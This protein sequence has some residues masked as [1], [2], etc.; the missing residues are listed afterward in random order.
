MR[1]SHTRDL[2]G[3]AAGTIA[4]RIRRGTSDGQG[5]FLAVS[6]GTTPWAML[7]RL[8]LCTDIRWDLVHVY[9]VDERVAPAGHPDRN[10]T[11]LE[12][13]LL[14]H[15]PAVCHP[16]PVGEPDLQAAAERY[17]GDLPDVFDLVHLGLGGD[18]H[19]ASL[20]PADPAL[21]VD[22][23]DVAVTE[24]YEG[25]RRM[26]LTYRSL[27]RARSILWVVAGA[28]KRSVLR[29]LLASD[30]HLPASGVLAE[31]A[32]LLTDIAP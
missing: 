10:L 24:P 3:E 6:G 20:L 2:V 22:D 9:Q 15:V 13:A 17:A 31:R 21:E 19:T 18:G 5:F 26:T 16:M 32:T 25:R 7:G 29:R 23:C 4:A 14:S 1:V 12:E 8:A 11:H 27:N 28:E 30:P